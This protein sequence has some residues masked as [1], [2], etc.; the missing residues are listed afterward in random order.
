VLRSLYSVDLPLACKPTKITISGCH[1]YFCMARPD[2]SIVC[3]RECDRG[4]G[5]SCCHEVFKAYIT[6]AGYF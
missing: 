6:G 1:R 2:E 5:V 4:C 3:Q